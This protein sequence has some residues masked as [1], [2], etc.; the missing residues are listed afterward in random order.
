MTNAQLLFSLLTSFPSELLDGLS[1]K[2]SRFRAGVGIRRGDIISTLH[3]QRFE[4][5]KHQRPY[6]IDWSVSSQTSVA[7]DEGNVN[8]GVWKP[9]V[10]AS[11][12]DCLERLSDPS[13]ALLSAPPGV[14]ADLG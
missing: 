14:T 6:V 11:I 3:G 2:L 1:Q 8:G 10:E 12:K 9:T 13:T 7:V 4:W 5:L